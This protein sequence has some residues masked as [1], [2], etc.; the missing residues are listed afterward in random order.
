VEVE[1]YPL[2]KFAFVT[3]SD[4]LIAL[5]ITSLMEKPKGVCM[6]PINLIFNWLDNSIGKSIDENF[7]LPQYA[8]V[9]RFSLTGINETAE[10]I[11]K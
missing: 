10:D 4:E 5:A 3:S 7:S 2:F 11:K 9:K 8:D 1:V 6:L